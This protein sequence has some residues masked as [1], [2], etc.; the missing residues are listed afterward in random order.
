MRDVLVRPSMVLR[1]PDVRS[2]PSAG[3]PRD[4]RV[5]TGRVLGWKGRVV[6]QSRGGIKDTA[7]LREV[8]KAL[9]TCVGLVCLFAVLCY[10]FRSW[11]FP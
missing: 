10:V 9:T 6:G 1:V 8:P 4:S 2:R 3:C 7:G 5:P 11:L